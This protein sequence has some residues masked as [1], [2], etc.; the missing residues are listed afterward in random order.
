ME[1][2]PALYRS[3]DLQSYLPSRQSIPLTWLTGPKAPQRPMPDDYVD[4]DVVEVLSA[5]Q[6]VLVRSGPLSRTQAA[7][8]LYTSI[9]RS[10]PRPAVTL[11]I[12]V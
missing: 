2:V 6:P 5:A 9:Y 7:L 12:I 1:S 10:A 4:A 8:Q 11:H 3:T